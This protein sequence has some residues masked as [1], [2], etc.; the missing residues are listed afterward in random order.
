M[1]ATALDVWYRLMKRSRYKTF[2]DLKSVFGAVDKVDQLFVFDIG[3]NKLRIVAAIHFNSD[4]V[5]IR[6]ILSHKEYDK[7]IWKQREGLQ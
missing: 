3:G 4:K 7:D 2:A 1:C 5:F 6:H